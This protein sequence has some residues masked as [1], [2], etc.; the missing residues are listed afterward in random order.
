M[1]L[2][3]NYI[4]QSPNFGVDPRSHGCAMRSSR[5]SPCRLRR[6]RAERSMVEVAVVVFQLHESTFTYRYLSAR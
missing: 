5:P 1:N 3:L 2:N 4:S 6:T